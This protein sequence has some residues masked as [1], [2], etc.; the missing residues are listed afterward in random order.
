MWLST[1]RR[2]RPSERLSVIR[3][4]L[5]AAGFS[6]EETHEIISAAILVL[7]FVYLLPNL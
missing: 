4:N 5:D 7:V 6:S 2:R 1:N 3:K